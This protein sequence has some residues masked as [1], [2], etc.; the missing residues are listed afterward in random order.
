MNKEQR[1]R[2]TAELKEFD[3]LDSGSQVQSIT[4]AYNALLSTIQGIMLN[5]E[6]PDGHDRAWS[7]LKDDAFKDLAAIQEGKLDALKDLKT[8]INR[9]GQ[10]LLKP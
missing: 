9:I 8:K 10:L 2:L 6:N 1:A 7:L 4:D 3:Q 5:S